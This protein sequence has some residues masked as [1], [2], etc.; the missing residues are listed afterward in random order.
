M[1]S[2]YDK[3][4]GAFPPTFMKD[5]KGWATANVSEKKLIKLT[6]QFVS[7]M[8]K[9]VDDVGEMGMD[10]KCPFDQF[11]ILSESLAYIKA[12]LNLEDLG[13]GRVDDPELAVP[14]RTSQNVLPG[15]PAL[16]MR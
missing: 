8:K 16:W 9:E 10:I 1:Q 14:E 2:Q 3:S 11:A 7:F 12:Q 5:L 4:S 15:K 13:V 6:M